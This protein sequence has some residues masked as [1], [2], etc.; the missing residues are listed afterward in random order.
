MPLTHDKGQ[1]QQEVLQDVRVQ[2]LQYL[3]IY[4]HGHPNIWVLLLGFSSV[5]QLGNIC[6]PSHIYILLKAQQQVA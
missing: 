1:S 4:I 5:L 6:G 2:Q 3:S